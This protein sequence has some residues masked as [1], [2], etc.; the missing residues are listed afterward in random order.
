MDDGDAD[1]G[2]L[3]G[4]SFDANE[5]SLALR[6]SLVE[7]RASILAQTHSHAQTLACLVN[8]CVCVLFAR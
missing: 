2:S 3:C 1:D 7:M 6:S 4:G 8:V 5:R